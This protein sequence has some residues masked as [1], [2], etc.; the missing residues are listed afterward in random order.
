MNY[1]AAEEMK[2]GVPEQ[3]QCGALFTLIVF[4]VIYS[5]HL[6]GDYVVYRVIFFDILLLRTL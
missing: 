4:R 2:K 1:N 5:L 3:S 6:N